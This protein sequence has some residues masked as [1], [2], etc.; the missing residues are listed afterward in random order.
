M[1]LFLLRMWVY[2]V[3]GATP[4]VVACDIPHPAPHEFTKVKNRFHYI[5]IGVGNV[6]YAKMHVHTYLNRKYGKLFEPKIWNAFISV[7]VN[8]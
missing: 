5:D 1:L 6:Y 4:M 3:M 7:V 2:C 8:V